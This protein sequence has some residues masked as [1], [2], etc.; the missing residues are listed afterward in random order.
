MNN[1]VIW[2]KDAKQEQRQLLGRKAVNLG[3]LARGLKVPNGFCLSTKAYDDQ[4]EFSGLREKINKLLMEYPP[5]KI[6]QLDEVSTKIE[7]LFVNI[8]LLPEIK[9]AIK[10]AYNSLA[11]GNKEFRVAV[12]SSATKEDLRSASFAGL[13][14]TFLNVEDIHE[15]F[16]AVKMC[17]ASLWTSRAIHYRNSKGYKNDQVKMAVIIQ[18]MIPAQVAGV[19]FTA[20]PVNNCRH[21]VMIEAARGL[22]EDLVSGQ[23]MGERYIVEKEGIRIKTRNDENYDPT[24]DALL[25]EYDVR[26]LALDGIKIEQYFNRYEDIEWALYNG[27]LYYLQARPLTTLGIQELPD[28]HRQKFSYRQR[29]IIQ[30]IF[31]RFPDP[32]HPIDGVVVKILLSARFEAMNKYGYNISSINWSQVEKGIFPEFFKPPT[33]NP[34]LKRVSLYAAVY[35]MLNSDPAQCWSNEQVH[36]L[37]MLSKLRNRDVENL[38]LEVIMDYVTEAFHH[39]HFFV[40]M[41]YEFFA[42]NRIPDDILRWMLERMFGTEAK[43][44]HD[45]LIAGIP[46]ITT[47]INDEIRKLAVMAK[48]F[49]VV[50]EAL[51]TGDLADMRNELKGVQGGKDFLKHFEAFMKKYGDRETYMGLGGIACPTWQ[52]VPEIVFGILRGVL[53]EKPEEVEKRE[54]ELQAR[55]RFAEE[56]VFAKLD[57]GLWQFLPAKGFVKKL[58]GHARSFATFRENSHYDMTRGLH[59]FRIL[60]MELGKRMAKRGILKDEKSIVYLSYYEVRDII[61]ILYNGIE[62]VDTTALAVKIKNRKEKQEQRNIRWKTKYKS[63]D[64]DA[65]IIKGVPASGGT[66]TGKARVIEDPRDFGKVLPGEIIVARFTN[67]SWTPL[68]TTASGLVVDTGSASSHAAIIAREYGIPAIMGTEKGTLTIKDGDRITIDGSTGLVMRELAKGA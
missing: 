25:N 23:V 14:N 8:D 34:G 18:E 62:E 48:K 24:A 11:G 9:E 3:D 41:R 12:R 4:V 31:E 33:M 39:F 57:K 26:S 54:Q 5:E 10:S 40:K 64:K 35:K 32:I 50:E 38:P 51:V 16:K 28:L 60:F 65:T 49:P 13:H 68:F 58:I 55:I 36:L 59:V 27:E 30:W 42:Q 46:C 61:N 56:R 52:E 37:D 53:N 63:I 2:I 47:K 29:E 66:V 20:N 22:G 43:E 7:E 1:Y 67:P 6:S 21:E 15:I 44:I 17:W 45:S 19:M